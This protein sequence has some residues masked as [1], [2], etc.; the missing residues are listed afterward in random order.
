M[1]EIILKNDK[2]NKSLLF[3][4]T[5]EKYENSSFVLFFFIQ[6]GFTEVYVY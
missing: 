5:Y 6:R 1:N 2:K 3:L 4:V